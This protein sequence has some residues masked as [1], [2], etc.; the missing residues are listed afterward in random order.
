MMIKR[1]LIAVSALFAG[2]V[3]VIAQATNS[4]VP[5]AGTDLPTTKAA[6]WTAGITVVTPL[7]VAGISK[8]IPKLPK[9][10]LPSITPLIGIGLGLGLNALQAAN[11]SWIDMAQAGA[12]AVFVREVFNQAV[13]SAM[14]QTMLGN[15]TPPAAPPTT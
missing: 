7:I 10:V 4:V 6:L 2:T 3:A 8:L 14:V 9:L 5:V 12:L 15:P 1:I 13:K 11:L